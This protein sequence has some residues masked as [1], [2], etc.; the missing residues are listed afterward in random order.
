MFNVREGKLS[1]E[2]PQEPKDK[3]SP[4]CHFMPIYIFLGR[5]WAFVFYQ[6]LQS[7]DGLEWYKNHWYKAFEAKVIIRLYYSV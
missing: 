7:F 6:I 3:I 1:L 4:N 5:E 2:F